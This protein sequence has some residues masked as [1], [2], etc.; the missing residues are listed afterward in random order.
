MHFRRFVQFG[1]VRELGQEDIGVPR[2]ARR[3]L[4]LTESDRLASGEELAHRFEA[5][6]FESVPTFQGLRA[7]VNSKE[8]SVD[9]HLSDTVPQQGKTAWLFGFGRAL[10]EVVANPP[11]PR[12]VVN[13]LRD[14]SRQAANRAF[15]AEFL[16]PV[17]EILAMHED[18]MDIS[19]IAEE[20]GVSDQVIEHQP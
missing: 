4:N 20:F 9:I 17:N 7:L 11:A 10:G 14:A 12:A 1:K 6:K 16:A 15:A 3:E 18:S 5:P 19:A 8:N 2:A 13:G